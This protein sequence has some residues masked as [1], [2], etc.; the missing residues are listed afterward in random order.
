MHVVSAPAGGSGG[1]CVYVCVSTKHDQ[2]QLRKAAS[3]APTAGVL[4]A[5]PGQAEKQRATLEGSTQFC[6]KLTLGVTGVVRVVLGAGAP[7]ASRR[8]CTRRG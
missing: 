7:A 1:L 8:R 2:G 4:R 5:E 6:P 3:H